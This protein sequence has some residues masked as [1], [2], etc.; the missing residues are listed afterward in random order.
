MG[1]GPPARNRKAARVKPSPIFRHLRR[2]APG[3]LA[4]L[5]ACALPWAARA[6]SVLLWNSTLLQ[7][8]QQTSAALIDGPPEVARE[9][10]IVNNA[11]YNAVNDAS[12]DPFQPYL[13]NVGPTQGASGEAA[14]LAAGYAAMMALFSAPGTPGNPLPSG[15][16]TIG[17]LW[18]S[19]RP[20]GTGFI[21][22]GG[23]QTIAA[24]VVEAINTAYNTALAALPTDS[25]T[26]A[27]LALGTANATQLVTIRLNDGAY[28]AIQNGLLPNA[29]PGSGV[30]PGVYVPPTTRPEMMPQWGSVT[31][32]GSTAATTLPVLEAQQKPLGFD[33]ANDP[34]QLQALIQ[35]PAYA[36]Q[37]LQTQCEGSGTALS[38]AMQVTCANAGFGLTPAERVAQTTSAL[39]WNDPG[40]TIQPPGHWLQ[41]TETVAASQNLD[42]LDHARLT[43]AVST[44]EADAGIA[45]WSVK[46]QVNL[47]RPIT[48]IHDCTAWSNGAYTNCDPSWTSVIATPPHPDYVAGHPAFSGAAAT[49][50]AAF[51]GTDDIPFTSTSNTYCN[52][53]TSILDPIGLVV[54]CTFGGQQFTVAGGDCNVVQP[55]GTASS[56]LICPITESYDSFSA[57]SSGPFGA[58]FSRVAGGIHTPMAVEDALALGN[59]VGADTFA[60][61]YQPVPEPSALALLLAQLAGL[62]AVTCRRRAP[63]PAC[64]PSWRAC[65]GA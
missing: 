26:T 15:A 61:N 39:F 14:A 36:Q 10:A 58:E 40:S 3:A 28:Q 50:L 45:A 53:G 6:D 22:P 19:D 1:C 29:P 48:A 46:Y 56:P 17:A 11:M 33:V 16:A 38:A 21:P 52:L 37:I 62:L 35:S 8:I 2:R 7:I 54:G 32:F 64:S 51:F 18:S 24:S 44:A 31:P 30:I 20:V 65:R 13:A 41:I 49:V 5:L 9:M 57:A 42:L 4:L 55:D 27:G 43:A 63:V 23:T 60:N 47:W 59:A 25:A 34:A 12:G